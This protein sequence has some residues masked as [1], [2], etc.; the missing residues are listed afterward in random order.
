MA[1]SEQLKAL[2]GQMPDPDG[3]GM[4]TENVDKE[5]IEK[6]IAA[7]H[8]GGDDVEA[9]RGSG[10]EELAHDRPLEDLGL[11][12]GKLYRNQRHVGIRT[13]TPSRAS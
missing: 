11:R 8:A 1:V 6:A 3:R 9:L 4:F 10:V 7:I 12:P 5:K 2:V 13:L